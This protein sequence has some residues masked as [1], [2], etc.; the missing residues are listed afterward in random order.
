MR[1]DIVGDLNSRAREL[2]RQEGTTPFVVLLAG[3]HA[4]IHRATGSADTVIGTAMA[5]R[6]RVEEEDVVGPFLNILPI[7]AAGLDRSSF[8]DLV[9]QLRGAVLAAQDRQ[10]LPI[11]LLVDAL[12][13][14]RDP[15]RNPLFQAYFNMLSPVQP[16]QRDGAPRA[17]LGVWIDEYAH[18]DLSLH[19]HEQEEGFALH[20]V[21]ATA[22]FD[23]ETAERL[24]VRLRRL[25]EQAVAC[26][27]E[28]LFAARLLE[29]GDQ[30]RRAGDGGDSSRPDP[31][32]A[33]ADSVASRFRECAQRHAEGVA[34][35]CGG[36][37]TT[38]SDLLAAAESLAGR[39]LSVGPPV[40]R[41]IALL[42]GHDVG[43]VIAVLGGILAGRTYV[44]LDPLFPQDRLREILSDAGACLIIGGPGH[45][46]H[47]RALA[48]L[49]GVPTLAVRSGEDA[50]P[51]VPLPEVCPDTPAYILYTSGS[52]GTPKG[53]F[54][55]QRNV[56]AHATAYARSLDLTPKDH[57]AMVATY[58]FDAAV[59]DLFGS[60]LH[61]ARLCLFDVRGSGL[62][63]LPSDLVAERV[64]I[65]HSTPTVF[66]HL[67]QSIRPEVR[68]P[69]IRAVV[70]GGEAATRADFEA[71]RRHV[72]S[73]ARF[74]NGLGPTECTVALQ[75]VLSFDAV[76]EREVLPVGHP[77]SG[78]DVLLLDPEGRD[79]ELIGEIAI[80]SRR[81]ALGYWNRPDLTAAA[82][83]PDAA[84]PRRPVYRT[85]DLGRRLSDDSI[86]FFGRRD[87]QIKLRGHRIELGEIEATLA[88]FSEGRQVAV[89]LLKGR[90][91]EARLVAFLTG[92]ADERVDTGLLRR[93]L[94]SL[95]PAYMIP[96]AFVILP[97]LPTTPTGKVDHRA[98][99]SLSDLRQD[100]IADH[101]AP[102]VGTEARL[103]GIWTRL[104]GLDH[105]SRTA[106]FFDLG[107]HSLLLARVQAAV[108]SEMGVALNLVQFF[109]YPTIAALAEHLAGLETTPRDDLA[110]DSARDRMA[111][112]SSARAARRAVPS[113]R[114]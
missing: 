85:G 65:Y 56:V 24:L 110:A 66:R 30:A 29:A 12:Q 6:T 57:L 63:T 2:A 4:L 71:F 22:L 83:V 54:Q 92:S 72:S 99:A 51:A 17:R 45:E 31:D 113:P 75:H 18:F 68:F 94:E 39:I 43:M 87:R 46:E 112:R 102:A 91:G 20:L 48:S 80:R 11:S 89:A 86:Q 60:L 84:E 79:N 49:A 64:T 40:Q 47:A 111:R 44:P 41:P 59:M 9:R 67:V 53:V 27:D 81:V 55:S 74:I 114:L 101:L 98:L 35:R 61:G 100:P 13:P 78:V 50:G 26:P 105:V 97:V 32:T 3:F 52:T 62:L 76:V 42:C 88:R 90:V 38:Y 1:I 73:G 109:R 23:P 104:L 107:G 58:G 34:V 77:V 108:E 19:V 93:R 16:V 96:T 37:D 14:E 8:R 103:A 28:Q 33:A 106:N 69:D 25:L 36:R 10:D 15:S 82:F 70:L 95:L 21:Y 5:G 7:R